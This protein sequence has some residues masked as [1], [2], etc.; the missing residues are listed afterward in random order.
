L[1]EEQSRPS[2]LGKLARRSER[3]LRFAVAGAINTVFGLAIYPLLLWL[4]PLLRVHYLIALGIA[5]AISLLFAFCTYKFGVFH[6]R[7]NLIQE[8]GTFSSF[9]LVHFAANWLALPLLVE[10]AGISPVIAQLAFSLV[11][12]VSSYFWHSRLTFKSTMRKM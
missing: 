8:F 1:E 5:Q 12:M 3:P 7:S 6:S 2:P 4:F 11:L 9:Y 10:A